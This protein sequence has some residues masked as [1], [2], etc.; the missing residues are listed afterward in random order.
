MPDVGCLMVVLSRILQ[1]PDFHGHIAAVF[2]GQHKWCAHAWVS[3]KEGCMRF[4]Q[5]VE[6]VGARP[7]SYTRDQQ[8]YVYVYPW[9]QLIGSATALCMHVHVVYN[10]DL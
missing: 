1:S 7:L 5:R 4:W 6:A 10:S 9:S 3:M 8:L 2:C